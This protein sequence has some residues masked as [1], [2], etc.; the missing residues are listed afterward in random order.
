[1]DSGPRDPDRRC[2]LVTAHI[3]ERASLGARLHVHG[4]LVETVRTAG[5]ARRTLDLWAPHALV[6]DLAL[7]D[8]SGID[9]CRWMRSRTAAPLVLLAEGE[10][11]RDL[12]MVA[13]AAGADDVLAHDGDPDIVAARITAMLQRLDSVWWAGAPAQGVLRAGRLTLDLG[14]HQAY[15]D[16]NPVRLTPREFALLQLLMSHPGEALPRSTIIEVLWGSDT[17]PASNV[18]E[19]QVRS[20]RHKLEPETT[21]FR[22]SAF[23]ETLPRVGYRLRTGSEEHRHPAP[24]REREESPPQATGSGTPPRH[25]A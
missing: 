4:F 18:V 12:R 13:F 21:D 16:E 24:L 20:L 5:E 8:A 6:V 1:M 22:P 11:D 25:E 2:L 9:L 15:I 17:T 3:R 23:I 19:R 7:P 14:R 10:I